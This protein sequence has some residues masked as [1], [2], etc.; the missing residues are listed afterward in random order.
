[1]VIANNADKSCMQKKKKNIFKAM[2]VDFVML[3]LITILF[4]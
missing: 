1:M 3:N 4:I 2:G